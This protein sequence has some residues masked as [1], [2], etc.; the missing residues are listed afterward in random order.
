MVAS[1]R[2]VRPQK[3]AT[4]LKL[5]PLDT[6]SWR[7]P[8][9]VRSLYAAVNRVRELEASPGASQAEITAARRA[10]KVAAAELTRFVDATRLFQAKRA[11]VPY[12]GRS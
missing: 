10:V 4:M 5:P 1:P 2:V 3:K 8:Q 9:E 12:F 6:P 7:L 11:T